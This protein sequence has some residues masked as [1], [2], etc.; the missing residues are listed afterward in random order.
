MSTKQI[1]AAVGA[2]LLLIADR[3]LALLS[4]TPTQLRA[5]A[6]D[7]VSFVGETWQFLSQPP[8]NALALIIWLLLLAYGFWPIMS[9]SRWMRVHAGH[10]AQPRMCLEFREPQPKDGIVLALQPS[11]A[12]LSWVRAELRVTRV[13]GGNIIAGIDLC[14]EVQGGRVL[15]AAV[16]SNGTASVTLWRPGEKPKSEDMEG[17]YTPDDWH[18]LEIRRTSQGASCS[19]DGATK[20]FSDVDWP[21][22]ARAQ[23]TVNLVNDPKGDVH[24]RNVLFG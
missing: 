12:P 10:V 1:V 3:V 19:V 6:T 16:V 18:V 9:R 23:I 7:Y 15:R 14:R 5:N 8:W 4:V 13:H 22:R 2:V 24:A 21:D 20:M 17:A 11:P